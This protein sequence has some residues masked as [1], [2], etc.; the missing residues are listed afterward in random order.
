MKKEERTTTVKKKWWKNYKKKKYV[1]QY[2]STRCRDGYRQNR[3]TSRVSRGMKLARIIGSR[4]GAA[5]RRGIKFQQHLRRATVPQSRRYLT[6]PISFDRPAGRATQ[7][8][9]FFFEG[10]GPGAL[11]IHGG[12]IFYDNPFARLHARQRGVYAI[13]MCRAR[14]ASSLVGGMSMLGVG[15]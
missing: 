4:V 14:S 5:S 7:H 10:P 2:S 3:Q 12:T 8:A 6:H 1:L 9:F 11:H 13:L 15:T